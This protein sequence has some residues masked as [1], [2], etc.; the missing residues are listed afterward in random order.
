MELE[1]YRLYIFIGLVAVLGL[2]EF[3][4]PIYK[5]RAHTLWRWTTN[6]GLSFFSTAIVRF[7]FPFVAVGFAQLMAS[8]GIGLFNWLQFNDYFV[9]IVSVLLLDMAIYWQHVLAHKWP[10]LW[11]LHKVHHS[12]QQMDVSTAVRFHP[13]EIIFSMLY[14]FVVI[15]LIGASPMAVILFELIL[16]SGA[17]FNHSNIRISKR[18]DKVLQYI[19]VTPN[20]HRIHHSDKRVETDSNYGFSISLWDRLFASYTANYDADRNIDI[21]LKESVDQPTY[22]FLWSLKFPFKK[23]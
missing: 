5:N 20:M 10:L 9:L 7:M 2:A 12:D 22:N 21:G 1:N 19:I 6:F 15:A 16:S 17:L 3:A 14:K 4:L 18:L 8:E 11:R 13:F 23:K